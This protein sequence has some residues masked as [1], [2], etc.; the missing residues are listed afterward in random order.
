MGEHNGNVIAAD[1]VPFATA[2]RYE[3]KMLSVA[4]AIVQAQSF[5]EKFQEFLLLEAGC[6]VF[7]SGIIQE[8][9]VVE[10]EF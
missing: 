1:V 9:L 3:G 4:V 10:Y 6:E 7:D 5:E 2:G 8:E